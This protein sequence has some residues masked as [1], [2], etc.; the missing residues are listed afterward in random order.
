[1]ADVSPLGIVKTLRPGDTALIVSYRGN[2]QAVRVLVPTPVPAS[3]R[4]PEVPT[5]NYIDREVFAKLRRL[6][7]VPA[8]LASDGEFLRRVSL[9]TVGTLPTPDEVRAFL[10]D[11]RPDSAP[12]DRRVAC[13]PDPRRSVGDQIQR[14]H[15]QQHRRAREPG[16]PRARRSQMWHDWL[17]KRFHDN[18]PYDEIVQRRVDRDQPGRPEPRIL[19]RTGR[20]P[21]TRRQ[22][23][24]LNVV[25]RARDP[26]P[27]L[28]SAGCG[29]TR[30]VG[31]KGGGGVPRRPARVCPVPQAPDRSLEPGRLSLLRQHLCAGRPRHPAGRQDS[32]RCRER[33][34]PQGSAGDPKKVALLIP[35]REVFVAKAGKALCIPKRVRS[36]RAGAGWAGDGRERGRGAAGS[37]VRVDALGRQSLLC[38]LV[39]QP[40]WGHY[41]GIGL[42][43]PVDD[44]SLT[45]P[46]SNQKLL[47]ALAKEFI[48][49]GTTF[50]TWNG[51]ILNSRTYQLIVGT[52]RDKQARSRSTSRTATFGR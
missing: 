23:P 48:R 14:H 26:R 5:V 28:A 3:F 8:D 9:D 33:R 40:L 52:E 4:Y 7:V 20:K 15:R 49:S 10:A 16:Q 50:G 12:Q 22:W 29:A 35:V 42:V 31:R 24:G 38:P 27:V 47:D 6:N 44:F 25:C 34:A 45:N 43:D 41:F 46:P 18:M 21:S 2:V 30:T 51:S 37:V 19:A 39:C 36:C 17:R 13:P 1:M 32:D 11:T